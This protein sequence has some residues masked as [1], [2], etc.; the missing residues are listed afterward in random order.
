VE[1]VR[2][3]EDQEQ[4]R[5]AIDLLQERGFT[6]NPEILGVLRAQDATK[7][8]VAALLTQEPW[9]NWLERRWELLSEMFANVV[10]RDQP[11][12][13]SRSDNLER[14][15]NPLR[16]LFLRIVGEAVERE[17]QR[18]TDAGAALHRIAKEA[19]R[20]QVPPVP[21]GYLDTQPTINSQLD[22]AR[23]R[24]HVIEDSACAALQTFD[25]GD[26]KRDRERLRG[27][28][29]DNGL[30]GWERA[31]EA[32]EHFAEADHLPNDPLS[33][34]QTMADFEEP[35]QASQ[36]AL[37][38]VDS[39]S[40]VCQKTR[41]LEEPAQRNLESDREQFVIVL[42]HLL[43]RAARLCS[44]FRL[45]MGSIFWRSVNIRYSALMPIHGDQL[46]LA[47]ARVARAQFELEQAEAALVK[48]RASKDNDA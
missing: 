45:D 37:A 46:R 19:S 47:E 14:L 44:A 31:R 8:E 42:G 35:R 24:L 27:P 36:W 41:H 33:R 22:F 12:S 10:K 43:Y 20:D 38:L 7:A 17:T 34:C 2:A 29:T 21:F 26:L 11:R 3:A 15:D 40:A 5:V 28:G 6:I 1:G 25:Q 39:I 16:L 13:G 30:E 18:H 4:L 48:A 23:S 9:V 32:F